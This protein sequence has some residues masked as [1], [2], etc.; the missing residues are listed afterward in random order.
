MS[1][2]DLV[3]LVLIFIPNFIHHLSFLFSWLGGCCG[4]ERSY[5]IGD[6]GVLAVIL[7]FSRGM[8]CPLRASL[9]VQVIVIQITG[10]EPQNLPDRPFSFSFLLYSKHATKPRSPKFSEYYILSYSIA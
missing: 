9:Y 10:R 5:G 2:G 1:D 8:H 3:T 6:N 4:V 7:D